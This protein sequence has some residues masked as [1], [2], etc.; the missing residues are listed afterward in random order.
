MFKGNSNLQ[1]IELQEKYSNQHSCSKSTLTSALRYYC[2][3]HRIQALQQQVEGLRP[4]ENENNCNMHYFQ[5]F[6]CSSNMLGVSLTGTTANVKKKWFQKRSSQLDG[7]SE[8]AYTEEKKGCL[9][10]G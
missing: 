2:H 7:K 4:C 10:Y 8:W 5:L 3:L 1:K 6:N 9:D